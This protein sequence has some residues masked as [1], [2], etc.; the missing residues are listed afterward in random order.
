MSVPTL[1]YDPDVRAMYVRLSD[2]AVAKSVELSDTVYVDLDSDGEPVG[3]EILEAQSSLVE[4]LAA[5][6]S[7][8]SLKELFGIAS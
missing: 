3:F 1:T 6:H 5:S 2:R 4:K 7:S 8:H